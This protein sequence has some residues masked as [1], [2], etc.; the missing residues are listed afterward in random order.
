MSALHQQT[1]FIPQINFRV[2]DI[3][4]N[5][6]EIITAIN[7]GQGQKADFVIFPELALSGYPPRDLL[8]FSSFRDDLENAL[9]RIVS[10]VADTYVILGT[11]KVDD[12]GK[13][14]NAA[15][16]IHQQQVIYTYYKTLLPDYDVFDESRYFYPNDDPGIVQINGIKIGLQICEDMWDDMWMHAVDVCQIQKD[17]GAEL[18]INISASPYTISK[19]QNRLDVV[20]RHVHD[21]GIPFLYVNLLGCQDDLVFDGRSFLVNGN[22]ELCYTTT[23]F[24]TGNF[25]M[26]GSRVDH[27]IDIS[28]YLDES[29]IQGSYE[30][31][32]MNLADYLVK[33]GIPPKLLVATSGGID[34]ALTLALAAEVVPAENII[35]VY[36]PSSFSADESYQGSRQLCENLG[37]QLIVIEIEEARALYGKMLGTLDLT[38][39]WSV[40]DEN[41]QS[42]IR[43][44]LVMY[45]SNKQGHL[46]LST[47]NKS[48]IATGYCTLYGDTAG[49]K[50]L[51]GD[52]YKTEVYAL[53]EFVNRN[54]EIIPESIITRPPT[55][56][57]KDNQLDVDSLPP[58]DELDG[59]LKLFIDEYHSEEEVVAEGYDQ[60]TVEYVINLVL[61]NEF[62]R[63]Q[64]V[65]SVKVSDKSFGPGWRMPIASKYRP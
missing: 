34:S 4:Y 22:G 47:G 59:I 25:L 28:D 13:M 8:Y 65:Q 42:R 61:R 48:E 3:A 14:R 30:A 31:I 56:E 17:K 19:A 57:L 21:V 7:E 44:N 53:S 62:K 46:L 5:T 55:A 29:P 6:E 39:D 64:L 38:N 20:G 9:Q 32:K 10:H 49:G 33:S 60:K 24:K 41:I 1:F 26:E 18:L 54:G 23:A 40:A 2:G 58:Y 36:M 15:V 43:S 16:L 11:P 37:V 27:P 50:N 45:L 63:A 52:L 35:A 51:I 12:R